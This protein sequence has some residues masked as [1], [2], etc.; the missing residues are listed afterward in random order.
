MS[1]GRAIWPALAAL[2]MTP[3]AIGGQGAITAAPN[4]AGAWFA[5]P[6]R[7]D[8]ADDFTWTR[9]DLHGIR[10]RVPREI[11]QVKQP[12]ID[13]LHFRIGRSSMVLRLHRDASRLFAQVYSPERARR[14]CWGDVGGLLAEAISFGAGGA[15]DYGFAA[16][17]PD[18]DR[19]EWLT[20]IV[21][22]RRLEE[23]TLL[24]RTLFT[25]VFPDER[26][27]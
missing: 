11:R 15:N 1:R 3:L 14:H 7:P 23:V 13:E 24:R 12:S 4:D 27:R 18:A 16:R 21:H 17:W 9:Y 2:A 10:I 22:G 8:S 6:C 25:I 20:A 5:D 26:R 19:G